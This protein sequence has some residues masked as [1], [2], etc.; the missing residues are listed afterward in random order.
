MK[1]KVLFSIFI[2]TVAVAAC[3]SEFDAQLPSDDVQVLIVDGTIVENSDVTFNLSKSFPL[4]FT[5]DTTKGKLPYIIPDEYFVSNAKLIIIG[6]NGYQSAPAQNLGR[7]EYQISVGELDNNLEYGIQIEYDGDTYQSTLSKP[8]YTPEIDSVSWIQPNWAETV[9]FRVS[10]HDNTEGAKFYLWNYQENWEIRA[11]WPTSIFL[12]T[13]IN[14]PNYGKFYTN[15]SRP[16]QYCWKS[17]RTNQ[18]LIG[19]TESLSENRI[20]NRR[21][22]EVNP[23][24][25]RLSFLYSVIVSQQAIS[26]EAFEYYENKI[27]LNQ[28]M[29]GLFTPQ[30]SELS[31]NITCI[32]DPTKKIM[33]YVTVSKNTTEKRIY[34]E[35]DLISRPIIT[36][37]ELIPQDSVAKWVQGDFIR[38]HSYG[39]RPAGDMDMGNPGFPENWSYDRCTDCVKAGGSKNKPD[40]WPNDHQ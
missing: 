20:I 10:T 38:Y 3:V 23:A 24:N 12:D 15:S 17:F 14:S 1:L 18:Y 2:L 35:S 13:D 40:F 36:G 26:K 4:D 16:Y 31:G 6:S 19:S 8:L 32:T 5:P 21:L 33:G 27:K 22:Y 30:P 7:G 34:V 29:G 39:Y 9:F 11:T 25:D 37:C 28:E